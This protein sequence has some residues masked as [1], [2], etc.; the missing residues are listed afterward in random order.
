M[1]KNGTPKLFRAFCW[2]IVT[3]SEGPPPL[4]PC[5]CPGVGTTQHRMGRVRAVGRGEKRRGMEL[6][7]IERVTTVHPALRRKSFKIQGCQKFHTSR[8]QSNEGSRLDRNREPIPLILC[9]PLL[10]G[11]IECSGGHNS[12]ACAERPRRGI[13]WRTKPGTFVRIEDG[14]Q[15][16]PFKVDLPKV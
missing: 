16:R 10:R 5:L 13:I 6:R 9:D 2:T 8:L 3:S 11:N 1:K 4:P 7:N 14:Y 15:R 12:G